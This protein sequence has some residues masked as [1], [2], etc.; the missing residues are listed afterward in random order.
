MT[1][2][3]HRV[4]LW[5]SR[6]PGL[7][8]A[9]PAFPTMPFSPSKLRPLGA[10]SSLIPTHQEKPTYLL[11]QG[12][13]YSLPQ[14]CLQGYIY[15]ENVMHFQSAVCVRVSE[16][17]G[18]Q[19]KRVTL[20]IA[21]RGVC[22][23]YLET[24]EWNEVRRGDGGR[25]RLEEASELNSGGWWG[26]TGE[27]VGKRRLEAGWVC[28]RTWGTTVGERQELV[29]AEGCM[30]RSY[31][32]NNLTVLLPMITSAL[33]ECQSCAEHFTEHFTSIISWLKP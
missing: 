27:E 20:S 33:T 24:S 12:L 14:T 30:W 10:H 8:T 23:G 19:V 5:E 31:I 28:A 15:P 16:V 4:R 1:H 17:R 32:T 3:G 9:F 6:V 22:A 7:P 21:G 26:F 11:T 25:Q 29:W 13:V 18:N 2:Q